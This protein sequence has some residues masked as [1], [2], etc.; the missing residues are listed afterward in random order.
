[1]ADSKLTDE[2]DREIM[3]HPW[4]ACLHGRSPGRHVTTN[5]DIGTLIVPQSVPSDHP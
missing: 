4:V 5:D 1:M 3:L 2:L